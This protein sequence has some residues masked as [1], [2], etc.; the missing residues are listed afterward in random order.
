MVNLEKVEF[1]GQRLFTK[2]LYGN[3]HPIGYTTSA[4]DFDSLSVGS[5][6]QYYKGYY[7]SND[8]KIIMAGKVEDKVLKQVEELF[9]GNDWKLPNKIRDNVQEAF[10]EEK[11]KLYEE[12]ADAVQSAIRIGKRFVNKK[13]PDYNKL[14]VLNMVYGGYFGSRLMS[15][16]REDKG[17]CYGIYSSIASFVED[18]YLCISTEVGATVTNQAVSEIYAEMERL[19][20]ELIPEEELHTVKNY[21]M[22][23]LLSDVDGAFNVSEVLRGLVVY[24]LGEDFFY[25]SVEEI[26][27]ATPD[28]LRELAH[29][30]YDPDTL[31]EAVVGKK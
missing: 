27:N 31:V 26:Q 21:M 3:N 11:T 10:P 1:L 22:G 9:G 20:T 4:E 28:E 16:L 29:K 14:K 24:D 12:K 5:L 2:A 18:S 15:N 30:Y 8:C 7:R 17:Y 6:Q 23:T 13:H 19:R 25:R